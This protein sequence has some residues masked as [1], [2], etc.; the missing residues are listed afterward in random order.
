MA[1]LEKKKL[2]QAKQIIKI[3]QM[4]D[5][6]YTKFIKSDMQLEYLM[7]KFECEMHCHIFLNLWT[8]HTIQ[9][10]DY[11]CPGWCQDSF[12]SWHEA[13]MHVSFNLYGQNSK[14]K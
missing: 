2:F 14:F 11:H 13:G 1:A 3:R 8:I 5:L 12:L 6:T 4:V 7:T 10:Q 9:I